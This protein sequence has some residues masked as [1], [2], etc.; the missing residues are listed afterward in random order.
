M[1]AGVPGILTRIVESKTSALQ[2]TRSQRDELELRARQ[3]SNFRNFR[4]ALEARRP[5]IIGEI[6]KGSPSKG[7]F[8]HQFD[9]ASIAKDYAAG[10]AAALSVLTDAEFFQGSLNDLEMAR[11]AAPLPVLRKDFTI[12]ELQVVEA[13]AHGADAVLLIASILDE[14]EMRKLRELAA[15]YRM[16]ALVEV[17]DE[18]ELAPALASGAEI[19]GVNNRNL[20]TFEVSLET[21]LR[22]APKIPS[23]IL[24][25]SES[26]L[27]SRAALEQLEAA[28]Y[29]AFLIGEHLMKAPDRAAALRGL[30]P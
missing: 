19:I 3:R 22:L 6:K 20:H 14:S 8:A 16:A 15:S 18:S 13:A 30:L 23:N 25:V 26:G 27:H 9:P 21:S 28:G 12:D 1:V 24:K 29:Q 17:H 10:G 11:S 5:A 7:T 4:A 2:R